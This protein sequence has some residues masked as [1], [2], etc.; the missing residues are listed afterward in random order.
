MFDAE[1]DGYHVMSRL[2]HKA[3]A[4][5]VWDYHGKSCCRV[6]I[7]TLEEMKAIHSSDGVAVENPEA[8]RA[9]ARVSARQVF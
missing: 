4:I 5:R 1:A 8:I 7:D 3:I 9:P 6:S 2:A